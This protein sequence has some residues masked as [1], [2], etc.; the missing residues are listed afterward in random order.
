LMLRTHV[1]T[2]LSLTYVI[3][4]HVAAADPEYAYSPFRVL[5]YVVAAVSQYVLD[6][7]LRPLDEEGQGEGYP[8]QE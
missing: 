7:F 3:D 8:C 5:L 4:Y 6:S 1:A 2:A